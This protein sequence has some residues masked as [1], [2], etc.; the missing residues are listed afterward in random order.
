MVS[1][2]LPD[3]RTVPSATTENPATVSATAAALPA[4]LL[5]AELIVLG[6]H[7]VHAAN[8]AEF[9]E[10]FLP[11]IGPLLIAALTVAAAGALIGALLRGTLR[12]RWVAV[13]LML[14]LLAW[15]QGNLLL[16][17]YGR[18]DGSPLEVTLGPFARAAEVSLWVAA[19]TAALLFHRTLA[20]IAPFVA[21]L[22]LA[23]QMLAAILLPVFSGA[24]S[25][26]H[27]APADDKSSSA[28]PAVPSDTPPGDVFRLSR[29]DNLILIILDTLTSDVAVEILQSDRPRWDAAFDGFAVYTDTLA[30]YATTVPSLAATMGA[31]RYENE[32]SLLDYGLVAYRRAPTLPS[33]LLDHGWAVDWIALTPAFCGAVPASLCW[34]IPR[35]YAPLADQRRLAAIELADLSLFRHAPHALKPSVYAEGSWT[36]RR[37][38]LGEGHHASRPEST[39]NFLIEAAEKLVADRDESVFKLIH[40]SGGHEPLVLDG[41]CAVTGD[42]LEPHD[43]Q[44]YRAQVACSLELVARLFAR[45]DDI[46]VLDDATIVVMGDH[47]GDIGVQGVQPHPLDERALSRARPL[48]AVKWPGT[49]GPI[50]LRRAPASLLDV[51]PTLAAAAGVPWSGDAPGRL[52]PGDPLLMGMGP[53]FDIG[54]QESPAVDLATLAEDADRVRAFAFH[55]E[56]ARRHMIDGHL[57]HLE[58]FLVRGALIDPLSWRL[59]SVLH[60]PGL[61]HDARHVDLGTPDGDRALSFHGW[62]SSGRDAD[63]TTWA[64]AVGPQASIYLSLPFERAPPP[65]EEYV[66]TLTVRGAVPADGDVPASMMVSLDGSIVSAPGMPQATSDFAPLVLTIPADHVRGEV[67]RLTLARVPWPGTALPPGT[68]WTDP[69]GAERVAGS[70]SGARLPWLQVDTL[71]WARR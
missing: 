51:A 23:L 69:D 20:R 2:G 26:K 42:R 16:G 64:G 50:A 14:A 57:Y 52:G 67:Q 13:L 53:A 36:L 10:G 48:L 15:L 33:T 18:L 35:P 58:R 8:A 37:W 3:D 66:V 28:A 12:S 65:G 19:L 55:S 17:H 22:V 46:G 25:L 31:P 43:V 32:E 4:L 54:L 56:D 24:D 41:T 34:P 62:G 61:R 6:P 9:S 70:E 49:H 44:G 45:L 71:E 5:S 1:E 47:G 29:N 40:V 39:A 60:A 38:L 27:D 68:R 63:G 30:P 7:A 59:H 21:T 11:L